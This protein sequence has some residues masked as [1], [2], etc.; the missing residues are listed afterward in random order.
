MQDLGVDEDLTLAGV[1][2]RAEK[3][4]ALLRQDM[5]APENLRAVEA[6]FQNV[7][8]AAQNVGPVDAAE[9]DAL[10]ARIQTLQNDI[11][12]A[13]AKVR[14]RVGLMSE[15]GKHLKESFSA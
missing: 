7:V 2:E 10:R 9:K 12:D 5:E 8:E 13:S 14:A 15:F 6:E 4:V 1:I 3:A 11:A